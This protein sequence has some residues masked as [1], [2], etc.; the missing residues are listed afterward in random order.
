MKK[1]NYTHLLF[2]LT[3]LLP[4]G[5]C[6]DYLDRTPDAEVTE[7]DVFGTFEDFQGFM[8][9]LYSLVI[10]YNSHALTTGMCIGGEIIGF[11]GWSSGD[12][13]KRGDYL[14]WHGGGNG[15]AQQSNFWCTED[16][17]IGNSD[18][19]IWPDS[20][21]GIRLANLALEKL[22]LLTDAT[23]EERNLIEG[24][25]YF[26]RAW[27]HWELGRYYGGMPYVDR[28]LTPVED[29]RLP[30]LSW[31]EMAERIVED[32]DRAAALL[33]ADWNDTAVGGQFRGANAGRATKGAALGFK[34]KTL[35]YAG[36]PLMN[37]FSTGN[38]TFENSYMERAAAAAWQVIQLAD[39][40]VYSLLPF[41]DYQHMFAR[42]DGEVPWTS[43]TIFQKAK[44]QVGA[45]EQN[46]RHGRLFTPARFGGNGICE[47][48]NQLYVDRFEMA[49]GTRYQ[50][51][52]DTDDSQRWENRDPRFRQNVLVDRDRAG[53]ANGTIVK[54]YDGGQDKG[55][56]GLLT[57]Y[58]VRKFWPVGVNRIDQVWSQYRYV[59][60]HLRLAEIYLIYAEAVTE[61]YG[62]AGSAP[63]ATLTAV[64]ALNVVRSRAG[65]PAVTANAEGYDSF[66]ELVRNERFVELCFEG[67]WFSDI[68]R[69]NI[70]HLPEM[71]PYVD[72]VFDQDWTTFNRQVIAERVFDDPRHYW[73]PIPRS[74]TQI[75]VEFNQNPGW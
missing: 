31:H 58:I 21:R 19:G 72:L 15:P 17:E 28:F 22:D 41:A 47:T 9:P 42:N 34:A 40:G 53:I 24:Q 46:N 52:Y 27:F 26:F 20:W 65:M 32:F 1:I 14:S 29:L 30:R 2:T 16:N 54:L 7:N 56:V 18:S 10:D 75:Y 70:A 67:H 35:L 25:A 44:S 66:R 63:G 49:D 64:D 37:R 69:W 62:A 60:P 8:E 45:G 68:R 59:T 55:H 74:Q 48:V 39:Q 6:D 51:A 61:A 38:V 73:M 23:P 71:K 36:S 43:E 50:E 11:Q 4:L 13:A 5:A 3:L 12:R 33:P 57:P